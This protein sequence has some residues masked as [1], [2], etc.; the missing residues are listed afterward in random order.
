MKEGRVR[1]VQPQLHPRKRPALRHLVRRVPGPA[2]LV[3]GPADELAVRLP[4]RVG[5][6]PQRLR[7]RPDEAKA[8]VPLQLAAMPAVDEA[9]IGPWLADTGGK[10]HDAF[11]SLCPTVSSTIGHASMREA[12]APPPSRSHRT[13][14]STQRHR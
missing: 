12:T 2:A 9:I 8:A 10:R 5:R 1:R 3:I 7:F 14:T 6:G 13:I 4:V 11:A